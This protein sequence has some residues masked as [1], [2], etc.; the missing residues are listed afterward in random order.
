[1][2]I[3]NRAKA[4]ASYRRQ[5]SLASMF[6]LLP[7]QDCPSIHRKLIWIQAITI[8]MKILQPVIL[9]SHNKKNFQH[10]LQEEMKMFLRSVITNT[11]HKT[12]YLM[13]YFKL[14]NNS[15]KTLTLISLEG[16][17]LCKC[18]PRRNHSGWSDINNSWASRGIDWKK[19]VEELLTYFLNI[20]RKVAVKDMPSFSLEMYPLI[21]FSKITQELDSRN[22]KPTILVLLG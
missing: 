10:W 17:K 9:D 14:E 7:T 4:K 5:I 18:W 22:N 2:S 19:R 12:I 20:L 13:D 1:M 8:I 11:S 15:A 21:E 6:N 16:L 3:R